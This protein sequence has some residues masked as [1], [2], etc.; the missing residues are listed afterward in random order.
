MPDTSLPDANVPDA[1]APDSSTDSGPVAQCVPG[2]SIGCVGPGGCFSNQVCKA[3]GSGYGPCTCSDAGSLACVPGQSIACV[4][5]GGC[6]SF[7]VCK[8]DGSGYGPCD[9]A[10]SGSA[11]D[12][13]TGWTPAQLPGLLAWFDDTYGVITHPTY[14]GAVKHRLDKSGNGN[15]ATS[16]DQ[17]SQGSAI[18]VD[19]GAV[20]GYDA[21]TCDPYA[22]LTVNLYPPLDTGA[23]GFTVAAVVHVGSTAPRNPGFAWLS[24]SSL[25]FWL[26]A[27]NDQLTLRVGTQTVATSI[28]AGPTFRILVGRGP[29]PELLVDGTST[30]GAANSA[31]LGPASTMTLCGGQSDSEIAEAI[32][33]N[34]TLSDADVANVVA[35]L[36]AKF[37]L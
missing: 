1:S 22:Q 11:P 27:Q 17:R 10:D 34:G 32:A 19:P 36:Q 6:S 33:V 23:G 21:F 7:Q 5:P 8:S 14:P 15:E 37:R 24:G 13:G 35:Y 2:Q 20:N 9:C 25:D 28:P 3:D 4:G 18:F 30:N 31:P 29:T 26:G 12:A 16:S